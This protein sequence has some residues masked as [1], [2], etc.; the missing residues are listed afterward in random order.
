MTTEK[1]YWDS[2]IE[3]MPLNKLNVLQQERLQATVNLCYENSAFY[4]RK[5]DEAGIKPQD[6]KTLEDLR[7]LS[8]TETM[9]LRTTSIVD[10][11]A[12][13]MEKVKYISS[14]SGTSG[15]PEPILYT[16]HEFDTVIDTDARLKWQMG[17]RPWDVVQLLSGFE[18]CRQAYHLLGATL[19]L[20]H[21][22]RW[23][24]DQQIRLGQVMGVTV[25]DNLP[26]LVLNYFDRATQLGMNMRES[27]VRLIIG[28]AEGWAESY[29]KQVESEYGVT[30]RTGYALME[31]GNIAG[32]CEAATGSQHIL[33][34][35]VIL[36][37]I[38]PETKK[39]LNHDQEGELVVTTL[40]NETMPL[41]RYRTGDVTSLLP[42]QPCPCGR[43]HPKIS[44]VKGR[45]ADAI[46]VKG[47]NFF[48]I[49]IEE[50]IAGVPGLRDE[51]QII[52]DM[53]G[54]LERLKI[55]VEYRPEI[56]DLRTMREKVEEA[57][58]QGLGVESEVELV[59]A[60]TIGRSLFKAKRLITTYGK[61]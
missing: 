37:V 53:P 1:K 28:V 48:P 57:L 49:D 15:L 11:I 10:K 47:K 19:L 12:V 61:A 5:L 21:A 9:E 22:G 36:E 2:E 27:K 42:Y 58:Y 60:G 20:E 43:T 6:I 41:I 34:D 50:V 44:K 31:V 45:V 30:L 25:I 38:D 32:E 16:K 35:F 33:S 40:K 24:L 56:K 51:F 39:V 52:V 13:P 17:V 23:N 14:T 26:S 3:V 18:C 7:N 59:P 54:E 8:L 29:R 55:K 4:R 46:K